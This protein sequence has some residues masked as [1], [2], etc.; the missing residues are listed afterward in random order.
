M[1]IPKPAP[2]ARRSGLIYHHPKAQEY[3]RATQS[4]CCTPPSDGPLIWH[5]YWYDKHPAILEIVAWLKE[6]PQTAQERALSQLEVLFEGA[7]QGT[8]NPR[9]PGEPIKAIDQGQD[10]YELR[11]TFNDFDYPEKLFRQYHAEPTESDVENLLV[12][13]HAHFKKVDGLTKQ[14][15]S[16]LQTEQMQQAVNRFNFGSKSRWGLE[17]DSAEPLHPLDLIEDLLY[18]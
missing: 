15:I 12:T 8:L 18:G 14:Q 4:R 6:L 1:P 5:S 17:K 2:P 7:S 16:G 11:W 3:D 13:S 10:F 9:D